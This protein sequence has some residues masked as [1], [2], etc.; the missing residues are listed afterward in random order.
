MAFYRLLGRSVVAVLLAAVAAKA[1][2]V[3][4]ATAA[5]SPSLKDRIAAIRA[6]AAELSGALSHDAAAPSVDQPAQIAWN[7]WKNE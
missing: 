6:K 2:A 7:D 3:V 4:P 1:G 5:D